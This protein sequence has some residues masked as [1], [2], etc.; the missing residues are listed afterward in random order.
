M[1]GRAVRG[2]GIVTEEDRTGQGD[3]VQPLCG[4]LSASLQRKRLKLSKSTDFRG[5]VLKNP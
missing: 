3:G 4:K 5:L 2:G 1:A